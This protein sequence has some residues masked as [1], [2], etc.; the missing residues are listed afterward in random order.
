MMMMMMMMMM[1]M[2]MM[3]MVNTMT[4]MMMMMTTATTT[5]TMTMIMMMMMMMTR[6]QTNSLFNQ[7]IFSHIINDT[8]LC[9]LCGLL[10]WNEDEQF[11]LQFQHHQYS[12]DL[13]RTETKKKKCLYLPYIHKHN[14][15]HYY[16][17]GDQA[18]SDELLD[19]LCRILNTVNSHS[20]RTSSQCPHLR[21]SIIARVY[22]S[23]TSV[24]YIQ[25]LSV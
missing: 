18:S 15:L 14:L 1:I 5:A 4:T 21:E 20:V 10:F 6:F 24:V 22:F 25:L 2:V 7:Y 8:L 17:A 19:D 16:K 11:L 13:N 23:Q 9:K 3:I 12:E